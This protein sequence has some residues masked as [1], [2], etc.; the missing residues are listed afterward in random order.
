MAQIIDIANP[1]AQGTRDRLADF[2]NHDEVF[3]EASRALRGFRAH[4]LGIVDT[5]K[6]TLAKGNA[7]SPV[8]A[9]AQCRSD[10]GH[11]ATRINALTQDQ[12]DAADAAFVAVRGMTAGDAAYA[13]NYLYT[14]ASMLA[15]TPADGSE[16]AALVAGI[17]AAI[18][19]PVRW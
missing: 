7:E 9:A 4:I 13:V 18:R 1:S 17:D 6:S 10:G 15:S 3:T 5:V 8:L 14:V 11:L 19:R 12:I 16:V 2:A